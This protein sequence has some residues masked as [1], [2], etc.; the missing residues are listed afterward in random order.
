MKSIQI[1][2]YGG[3]EVLMLREVPAPAVTPGSVL[4]KLEACGVNYIDIYQRIGLYPVQLPATLGLEGAGTIVECAS[5]VSGLKVGA[6][7]AFASCLGAYSQ[8]VVAPASVLIEIPKDVTSEEAAAAML[9][10]MTAHYLAT[11][12]FPL[13]SGDRCLIHAGAGGV[14]LLLIQIAKLCGATVFTTV[15]TDIKAGL[16][17]DAG[18]DE[19]INY[20]N[21][22]FEKR[23]RELTKGAGV[24]VVYD[25]V[26][27]TTF[28]QS[29]RSLAVRGTLV[30]FGQ[31]SGPIEPFS[32]R[33]LNQYGSLY[34][35]RPSLAHYTRT[36]EELLE[37]AGAVLNWVSSDK[38]RLR[39]GARYPL[40]EAK[41]AHEA[42]AGRATTGK[43][44]LIP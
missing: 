2:K 41:A 28:E 35:T 1:E 8:Y 23:I 21:Q 10:G 13:K 19:V 15:S 26:G 14:G 5:D 32:P 29:L 34:L 30:S 17:K 6:R 20:S 40:S 22:D 31:S 37:R 39:I 16:A 12:T 9:Q 33:I 43:I 27:K 4:I 7:V 25:S 36:R 11:S 18:A 42:L 44:L 3:P 38:I 24:H